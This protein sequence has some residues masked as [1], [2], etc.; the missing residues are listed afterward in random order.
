MKSSSLQ[1]FQLPY[2]LSFLLLPSQSF[3]SHLLNL[4]FFSFFFL[5]LVPFSLFPWPLNLLLLFSSLLSFYFFGLIFFIIS[6]KIGLL[7][8]FLMSFVLRIP[9]FCLIISVSAQ[10]LGAQVHSIFVLQKLSFL[11]SFHILN[12]SIFYDLLFLL[13]QVNMLVFFIHFPE[14]LNNQTLLLLSFFLILSSL[15]PLLLQQNI[16]FSLKPSWSVFLVLSPSFGSC[17]FLILFHNCSVVIVI[18]IPFFLRQ[19]I[20]TSV[21]SHLSELSSYIL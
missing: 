14:L 6:I 17:L 3:F 5:I 18:H 8:W 1:K 4:A 12:F 10:K 7:F 13:K 9:R 21:S 15:N 20:Q 2:F 16:Y 19:N 11:E